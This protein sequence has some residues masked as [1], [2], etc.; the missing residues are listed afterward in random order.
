[1]RFAGLPPFNA[2][3]IAAVGFAGAI[4]V[5]T[6]SFA[7]DCPG[8]PDAIGTS[9]VIEIDPA[10]YPRVGSLNYSQSLPLEDHEVVLTFDDGPLPP[11]TTRVLDVLAAQCAKVNFFLVGE[12]AR[13]FP[14]VVKRIYQDGHVIGTHS[15]DHPLRFGQMPIEKI[16][17]EIDRGIAD[18]SAAVGDPTKVAPFFRFPGFAR[19]D[20]AEAELAD[21]KLAVFSTDTVED[22]WHRHISPKQIISLAL[23]R[24]EK[25]GRGIL[26]LHDIHPWT[27]T[28]LP[29]L[30]KQ[31]KDRG[32]RLVQVVP[33]PA[34][35][36]AAVEAASETTV[37]WTSA[38]QDFIDNAGDAPIWP[39]LTPLVRPETVALDA[40]DANAFDTHYPVEAMTLGK[41][42]TAAMSSEETPVPMHASLWPEP[43][44]NAALANSDSQLPTPDVA[45]I[46]WPL[47]LQP[48]AIETPA[49]VLQSRANAVASRGR[50][51]FVRDIKHAQPKGGEPKVSAHTVAHH[52][53]RAPAGAA[54]RASLG[55]KLAALLTPAK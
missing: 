45:D 14:A 44:E 42:Q 19:S 7:A 15:E 6:P 50:H 52:P 29:D 22:D 8:N 35:V 32:F 34:S 1:M 5:A 40:P 11:S 31:L 24:L 47:N 26:L 12:M 9:R 38:Q 16:R 51:R 39:A 21:R 36:A 46:G 27:A 41:V 28:A 33:T 18:V 3:L 48:R 25:R 23:S 17:W 20:I 37:A 13:N 55:D 43:Q 2:A 4:C 30:L 53:A 54:K 10:E 49:I